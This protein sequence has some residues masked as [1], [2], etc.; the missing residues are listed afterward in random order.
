M[1]NKT[2]LNVGL[3][4]NL[5]RKLTLVFLNQFS[6]AFEVKVILFVLFNFHSKIK[7]VK[8]IAENKEVRILYIRHEN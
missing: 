8:K 5:S 3:F 1:Y 2:L 4:D 7:R 6:V